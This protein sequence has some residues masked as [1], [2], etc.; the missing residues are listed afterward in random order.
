MKNIF[1]E[2]CKVDDEK[3]MVYG[4]ASTEAL[5]S[6]GEVV[7]KSAMAEALD[8]YM[9]FANIREMHQP[10]AVGVAKSAEMDDKGCF[11]S[12][13][14]VDDSAWAKVKAG[15]YKGFSIGGKAIAKAEGI[16][17]S[18][19]LSEISLVDRPANPEALITVWKADGVA[20]TPEQ[21]VTALA[22]LLDKG[23]ISP[24]RLVELAQAELAKSKETPAV[25]TTVEV[26]VDAPAAEPA[27]EPAADVPAV[28]VPAAEP[29]APAADDAA[30]ADEIPT[31]NGIAKGMYTVAWLSELLAS[32]NN[33][34]QDVTWEAEYEADGSALPAM[35]KDAVELLAGILTDMVAEETKELTEEAKADHVVDVAKAGKSISAKNMEKLQAMHDHCAAMGAA[36]KADDAAKHDHA[37]DVSKAHMDDIAAVRA[38]LQK[39]NDANETLK[40]EIAAL[41]KQPAAGKA[42]LNAIAV[43]KSQD[44]EGNADDT[45]KIAPVADAKGAVND[46]ASLIKAIHSKGGVVA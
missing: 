16:I 4:Y 5:D 18:L 23:D 9:K 38:D 45:N 33:L 34:R 28:E 25:E 24:Q 35:L 36:C 1:A 19:K 13:H 26:T 41:K 14:V 20:P 15:V 46:V 27:A 40:S 10:S 44:G 30:K 2:I 22:D 31:S 6:Q 32:L 42:L 11:I 12:A 43:S 39:L 3:R 21:A 29:D 17:S 37:T 8:D 7:T